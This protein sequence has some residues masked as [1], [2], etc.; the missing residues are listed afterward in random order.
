MSEF[1]MTIIGLIAVALIIAVSITIIVN[2]IVN[3]LCE[4]VLS[5]QQSKD[6]TAKVIAETITKSNH[7][8]TIGTA[9]ISADNNNDLLRITYRDEQNQASKQK[10]FGAIASFVVNHLRGSKED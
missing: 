8:Y 5:I 4:T 6:E 7:N 10:I 2:I 1:T 9:N 3:K